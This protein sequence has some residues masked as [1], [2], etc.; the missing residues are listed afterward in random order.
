LILALFLL[1]NCTVYRGTAVGVENAI[2]QKTKTIVVTKG[3]EKLKFK[4]LLKTNQNLIGVAKKRRT[5][6]Y[7]EENGFDFEKRGQLRKYVID[8][9]EINEIYP[10]NKTASTLVSIGISV[11]TAFTVLTVAAGIVFFS[12][13]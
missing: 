2:D 11:L 3:G 9:L 10:K 8:S 6:R 13:W 12:S 5:I 1:Q 4:K 7:L